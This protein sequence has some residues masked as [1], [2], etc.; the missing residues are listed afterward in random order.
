MFKT[1]K[2][3]S[4]ETLCGTQAN[5]YDAKS[6]LQRRMEARRAAVPFTPIQAFGIELAENEW[7]PA[8]VEPGAVAAGAAKSELET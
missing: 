3:K 1:A 6:W 2:P 7:P 5:A 4:Y 8:R